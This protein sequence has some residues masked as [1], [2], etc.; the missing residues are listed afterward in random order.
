MSRTVRWGILS[1]ARIGVEQVIP[2][3]QAATNCEVVAIASRNIDKAKQVAEQLS[4]SSA[5]GSYEELLDDPAVDAIY[6]PLPNH[7]HRIWSMLAIQ[8]GKHVLCEK[9][10]GLD[11][12]DAE[13]LLE[14][15]ERYPEI[16][17]MEA[18]MYRFHPQWIHAKHIIDS[19]DIGELRSIESFFSYYNDDPE[20]ICN[21]TEYGGGGLLDIGCYSV[22]LSRF[23]FNEEPTSVV[24]IS[25]TDPI[26]GTDRT[27]SAIMNFTSGTST[28]TCSTQMEPCQNVTAI[29]SSG[30]F[31]ISVPFNPLPN[32]PACL[33][34]YQGKVAM[35]SEYD[36]C[37][38]Y[39]LQA[40][41]FADA[42]LE[43]KPVP[44]PL[45]DAVANMVVLDAIKKS[46]AT[47]SWID[48]G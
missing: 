16:R 29:G 24:G 42:I 27:T 6:N 13:K 39:T 35:K 5:Y 8:A 4:I 40:E 37:N 3:T 12:A 19:G 26:F 22:S 30:R 31:T 44:T 45:E 28:F 21:Q 20:S 41:R 11:L 9:P 7:L 48:L 25:H 32:K 43:A 10:I 1:T 36:L 33:W 23:L 38:Q 15:S 17:V 14:W 2:A 47:G 34:I 18:F 46:A